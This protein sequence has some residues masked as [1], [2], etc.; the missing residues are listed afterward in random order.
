MGVE[1][2]GQK[3]PPSGGAVW[4]M[5]WRN[6]QRVRELL[7]PIQNG[8][9]GGIFQKLGAAA[10][11]GVEMVGQHHLQGTCIPAVT[12]VGLTQGWIVLYAL[13]KELGGMETFIHDLD[14]LPVGAPAVV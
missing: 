2:G 5:G 1:C 9:V 11:R 14:D 4:C 12:A 3:A 10:A 8:G 6:F 7:V 13:R